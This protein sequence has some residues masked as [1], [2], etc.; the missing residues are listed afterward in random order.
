LNP[1]FS[2]VRTDSKSPPKEHLDD[3]SKAKSLLKA[4][5]LDVV[6]NSSQEQTITILQELLNML[7]S[8]AKQAS[9]TVRDGGKVVNTTKPPKAHTIT[10]TNRIVT[11]HKQEEANRKGMTT[12]SKT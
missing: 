6:P 8:G 10:P 4:L 11:I 7:L 12:R 1:R 3:V 5:F 9:P 2:L